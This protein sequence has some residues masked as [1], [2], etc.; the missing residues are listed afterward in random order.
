MKQY[1]IKWA[2]NA[3][4]ILSISGELTSGYLNRADHSDV[5][6]YRF[7]KDEANVMTEKKELTSV[8]M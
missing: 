5:L 4:G 1:T 2:C 8:I 3:F 6:F 7:K